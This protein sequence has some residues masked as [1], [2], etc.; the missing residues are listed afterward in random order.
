MRTSYVWL[1]MFPRPVEWFALPRT[2]SEYADGPITQY[3]DDSERIGV[4]F[5]QRI[6]PDFD[7]D[8]AR[9]VFILFDR[10]ATWENAGKHVLGWGSTVLSEQDRL[11]AMLEELR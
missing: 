3:W 6:I 4:E 11:F 2:A 9:D 5:K 7:G 1:P 8:V 10:E